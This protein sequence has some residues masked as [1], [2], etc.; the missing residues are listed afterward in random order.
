MHILRKLHQNVFFFANV[1]KL[2]KVLNDIGWCRRTFRTPIL[3][4]GVDTKLVWFEI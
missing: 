4:M 3:D 2:L 1:L